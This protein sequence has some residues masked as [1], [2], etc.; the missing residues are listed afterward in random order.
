M[1]A[2][3]ISLEECLPE[4]IEVIRCRNC[5]WLHTVEYCMDEPPIVYC[6]R[7]CDQEVGMNEYC[8]R[9]IRKPEVII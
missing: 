5:L 3:Q 4:K 7:W 9:A 1:K 2:E 8:S 6:S